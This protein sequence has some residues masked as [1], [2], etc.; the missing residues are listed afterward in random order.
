MRYLK[1]LHFVMLI[2]GLLTGLCA[3]A[4]SGIITLKLP[5]RSGA[6]SVRGHVGGESHD[7]YAIALQAGQLVTITLNAKGGKAEFLVS[8]SSDFSEARPVGFGKDTRPQS[9]SATVTASKTYYIYVTAHPQAQYR[10][11]V[12]LKSSNK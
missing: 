8:D 1:M 12:S 6:I 4:S 5:N 10:L 2:T 3:A 7:A 9:W 11:R